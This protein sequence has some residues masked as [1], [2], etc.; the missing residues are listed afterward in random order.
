MYC[1]ALHCGV[2]WCCMLFCLVS[3]RLGWGEVRGGYVCRMVCFVFGK[4]VAREVDMGGRQGIVKYGT[5]R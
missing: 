1:I 3:S 5:R 4:E 2:V